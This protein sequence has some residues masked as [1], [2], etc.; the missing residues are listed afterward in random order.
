[1]ALEWTPEMSVGIGE[2]D[3]QHRKLIRKLNEINEAVEKGASKE[4]IARAI[5][6]LEVY[7]DEHFKAEEAY[8][9]S[10]KYRDYE[11]HRNVHA[12]FMKETAAVREKFD[13]GE[14]APAEV[15]DAVKYQYDWFV[16]HMASSDA[17]MATFLRGKI[18]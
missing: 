18:R 4:E 3:V 13:S 9:L 12:R 10:Y 16:N 14:I 5:R 2:I 1:M 7:S 8:M 6:F 15:S 11:D 17:R